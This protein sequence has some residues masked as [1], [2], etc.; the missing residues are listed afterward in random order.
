[1]R[2]FDLSYLA[3][4]VIITNMRKSHAMMGVFLQGERN[5]LSGYLSFLSEADM[6]SIHELS[7][8][9]LE[10]VGVEMPVEAAREM[11]KRHGAYVNGSRVRLSP[12]LIEE[13]L[14]L[15]PAHFTIHARNPQKDVLIGGHHAVFA[16]GYGAPILMDYELGPRRPTM[17]DYDNLVRLADALPNMDMSGHL[18]V[19][20]HDVPADRAYLHMLYSHMRHSDKP[21]IGSAAGARGA[22]ASIEMAGILF[23]GKDRLKERPAMIALI[24]TLSPLGFAAEMVEALMVFAEWRQPVVIAAMAQA[25]A[26][27][28]VTI[29]GVL[30]QQNAEILAG[31]TLAQCISPGT[32]VVYGST[33]TIMDMH[34]AAAAIGSPEYAIFVVC[35]AQM[36]RYYRLPSRS[37]GCLTDSQLP[38]AQAGLESMMSMLTAINAGV[39]FVL[40]A[41]GILGS[42]LTFSYEKMVIDDEICGMVRRYKAG[43]TMTDDDLAYETIAGVGPGGNYLMDEHTLRHFRSAFYR[44]AL[45]NRD[46]LPAWEEKGRLDMGRRAH[47]RCKRLLAEHPIPPLDPIIARQLERY[48]EEHSS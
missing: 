19:E 35:N 40:H 3:S 17:Q 33:S 34:T 6:D 2:F 20:P 21:F 46:A 5:V 10:R 16:P 24:N 41:A 48:M 14:N 28:P 36:A 47:M 12:K 42:Y 22:M 13:Q 1:M 25:G 45:C 27:G 23:G 44:P 39:H 4:Y 37:G 8:R 31:I 18:L 43:F 38:D 15:A 29:P 32:P 11:L 26:T 7:L 9:L 30:V